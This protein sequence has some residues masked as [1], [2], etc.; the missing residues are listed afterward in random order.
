MR[1]LPGAKA[2]I[3]VAKVYSAFMITFFAEKR[4]Q[5]WTN[6]GENFIIEGK[7]E[8]G[9]RMRQGCAVEILYQDK[10]LLVCI[11][12]SGVPSEGTGSNALPEILKMQTGKN[13][14]PVHRLD[15]AASGLMVY[16]RRRESAAALSSAIAAGT[17]EKEYFALVSGTP[18]PEEGRMED[19]LY[20]D[21]R[22]GRVYPVRSLRK[23]VKQ[24]ALTYKTLQSREGV[25]LVR[26]QL[27]TGRTHQIRVQFASRKLPLLGDGKYGSRVKGNLMLWSCRL[28][29][30]HPETGEKLCFYRTPAWEG[31]DFP[32]T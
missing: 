7:K 30:S 19:F 25:S 10:A 21:A 16:A 29:F 17:M 3:S 1:R 28:A 15:Q 31:W 6:P 20:H 27:E 23:G 24:A 9:G 14:W 26:V 11:K 12:P 4:N 2:A 5:S 32:P 13:V 18:Q 22:K 8:R